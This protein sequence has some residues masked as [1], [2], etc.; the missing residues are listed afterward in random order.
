MDVR[1]ILFIPVLIGVSIYVPINVYFV[2][3]T[4]WRLI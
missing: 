1:C 4:M 2:Y 3:Q